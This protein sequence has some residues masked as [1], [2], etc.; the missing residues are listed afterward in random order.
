MSEL[1]ETIK[2]KYA[3]LNEQTDLSEKVIS[4]IQIHHKSSFF[5]KPLVTYM[6]ES[7]TVGPT[8]NGPYDIF[9]P[10]FPCS[11]GDSVHIANFAKKQA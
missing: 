1:I 8:H 5:K 3:F 2:S 6:N 11:V 7:L 9:Q 10:L 4:I